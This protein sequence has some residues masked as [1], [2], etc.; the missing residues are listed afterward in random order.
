[1]GRQSEELRIYP[2]VAEIDP[3]LVATVVDEYSHA[4]AR[5]RWHWVNGHYLSDL[6]T[7]GRRMRARGERWTPPPS[8]RKIAR[9]CL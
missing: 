3:V 4:A 2:A 6:A 9:P 1:M 7:R 5:E 8:R